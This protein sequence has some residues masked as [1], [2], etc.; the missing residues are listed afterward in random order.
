MLA[1]GKEFGNNI[2]NWWKLLIMG[3]GILPLKQACF[4]PYTARNI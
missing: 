2:H 4:M 1:I 3:V